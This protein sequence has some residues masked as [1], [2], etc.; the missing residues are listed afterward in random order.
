MN[1]QKKPRVARPDP[2][3]GTFAAQVRAT[4]E[5]LNLDEP[6]AA[7]YFGVPVFTLRK[8]ATGERQPG[9][10]VLRLFEVLGIV[11][12]MAPALHGSFLPPVQQVTPRKRGRVKNLAGEIGHVEKS[13]STGS[14]DSI[15]NSV[16]SK[17]PV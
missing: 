6:R 5:R 15:D 8:W 4:L 12:A 9:A 13:G 7:D 11:E 2:A 1:T 10:A 16:M 3:P 14:T 17:N